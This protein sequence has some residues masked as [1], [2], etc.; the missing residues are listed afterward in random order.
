MHAHVPRQEKFNK[1]SQR[2]QFCTARPVSEG[3]VFRIVWLSKFNHFDSEAFSRNWHRFS[4]LQTSRL[5]GRFQ[6]VS[7]VFERHT[8]SEKC[9]GACATAVIEAHHNPHTMRFS[10]FL[11]VFDLAFEVS[12][13]W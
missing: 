5:G 9:V 12:R 4:K 10:W 13:V 7:R 8:S 1:R 11:Q 3:V 2:P 6:V